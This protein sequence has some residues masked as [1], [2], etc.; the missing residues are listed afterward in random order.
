ME[1]L[2]NQKRDRDVQTPPRSRFENFPGTDTL[3]SPLSA[4]DARMFSHREWRTRGG[5]A[6][7]TIVMRS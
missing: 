7:M 3:H 2:G 1:S 6:I 4:A 5:T